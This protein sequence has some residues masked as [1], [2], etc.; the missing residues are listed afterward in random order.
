MKRGRSDDEQVEAKKIKLDEAGASKDASTSS[1]KADTT[2]ETAEK[3]VVDHKVEPETK[4]TESKETETEESKET[5]TKE[6]ESKEVESKESK[7]TEAKETEAKETEAKELESKETAAKEPEQVNETEPKEPESKPAPFSFQNFSSSSGF[8]QFSAFKAPTVK[9]TGNPWASKPK[10]DEKDSSADSKPESEAEAESKPKSGFSFGSNNG[11][12]SVTE[13]NGANGANG[14]SGASGASEAESSKVAEFAMEKKVNKTGEEDEGTLFSCHCRLFCVDLS[15]DAKQ[16]KER[17]SG[18]L[19]LNQNSE[20]KH[21]LIMR[22]DGVLRVQLNLPL[23]KNTKV[24]KGFTNSLHSENYI[25][26]VG[27]EDEKPRQFALK[28]SSEDQRDQLFSEIETVL[29]SKE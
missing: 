20:N 17:G 21:R 16:W 22:A 12:N 29:Q 24:F 2:A 14:A 3:P 7:E 26:L 6:V 23:V 18:T 27:I 19:K 15:S 28:L 9:T 5:E 13:A 8:S 11:K 1:L 4:E 25:R 10:T